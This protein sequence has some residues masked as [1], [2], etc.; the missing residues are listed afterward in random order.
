MG[1]Q[2]GLSAGL[3]IGIV[4]M[5]SMFASRAHPDDESWIERG[6]FISPIFGGFCCGA[7]DCDRMLD[8]SVQRVDGG[9]FVKPSDEF[10]PNDKTQASV[11][12]AFHWCRLYTAGAIKTRCLFVPPLGF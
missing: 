2:F 7:E 12:G 9:F 11:D 8:R 10:I 6:N 4:N 3:V 1:R 5:L